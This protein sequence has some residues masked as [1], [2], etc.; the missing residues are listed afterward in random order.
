MA[1]SLTLKRDSVFVILV[2]QPAKHIVHADSMHID[3]DGPPCESW[4]PLIHTHIVDN[5]LRD[6]VSPPD[7]VFAARRGVFSFLMPVVN[8]G[9]WTMKAYP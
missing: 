6:M 1:A 2:T 9:T 8:D 4:Q 3:F 7:F 5:G